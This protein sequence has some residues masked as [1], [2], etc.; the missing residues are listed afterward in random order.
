MLTCQP[1]YYFLP[2][3]PINFLIQPNYILCINLY[4]CINVI[5]PNPKWWIWWGIVQSFPTLNSHHWKNDVIWCHSPVWPQPDPDAQGVD[6]LHMACWF[7]NWSLH[8]WF[9]ILVP[10]EPQVTRST[11]IDVPLGYSTIISSS[12][13][14]KHFPC[15]PFH[16]NGSYKSCVTRWVVISQQWSL[17]VRVHMEKLNTRHL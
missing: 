3:W 8:I 9:K 2:V 13:A 1:A 6:K 15:L 14:F 7:W 4:G 5:I 17:I 10:R 11:I 16:W 12:L